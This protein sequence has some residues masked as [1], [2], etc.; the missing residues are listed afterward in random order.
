VA[1]VAKCA[2]VLLD[3]RVGMRVSKLAACHLLPARK[4]GSDHPQVDC[5]GSFPAIGH[6]NCNPLPLR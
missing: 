4:M 6:I 5:L 2:G 3:R 1:L